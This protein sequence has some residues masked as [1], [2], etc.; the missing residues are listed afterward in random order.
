MCYHGFS[1]I[2]NKIYQRR[3]VRLGGTSANNVS[4]SGYASRSLSSMRIGTR[5]VTVNDLINAP[6]QIDASNPINF[7]LGCKLC[8]RRSPL[9]NTPCL[10]DSPTPPP[11][12]PKKKKKKR[13]E[14]NRIASKAKETLHRVKSR[15]L[16]SFLLA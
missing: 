3:I 12:P 10:I 8:I 2:Q 14:S 7:P 5:R 1:S 13:L 4:L 11:P 6:S 16:F 15:N 9:I